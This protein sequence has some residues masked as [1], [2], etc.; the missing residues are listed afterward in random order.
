MVWASDIPSQVRLRRNRDTTRGLC[1]EGEADAVEGAEEADAEG[2]GPAAGSATAAESGLEE[3]GLEESG[4]EG[5]YRA[6]SRPLCPR[7]TP[8]LPLAFTRAQQLFAKLH[9]TRVAG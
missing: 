3:S 9:A 2:E 1:D 4:L 8:P 6:G 5:S 7:P